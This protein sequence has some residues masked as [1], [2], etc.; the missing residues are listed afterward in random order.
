[1]AVTKKPKIATDNAEEFIGAA[2]AHAVKTLKRDTVKTVKKKAPVKSV[3]KTKLTFYMDQE[4]YLEW[5][6]YELKQLEQGNKVSFQ[7]VVERYMNRILR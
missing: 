1:M 4:M 7:G 3:K 5:K 2:K 6:A